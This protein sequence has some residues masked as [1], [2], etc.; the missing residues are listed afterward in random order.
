MKNKSISCSFAP[1]L[2]TPSGAEERRM[3]GSYSVLSTL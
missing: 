1:P 2:A 3:E